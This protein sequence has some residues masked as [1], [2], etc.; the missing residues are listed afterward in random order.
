[1]MVFSKLG[2]AVFVLNQDDLT[3]LI[4]H[5]RAQHS[6]DE[7][8]VWDRYMNSKLLAKHVRREIPAPPILETRVRQVITSFYNSTETNALAYDND[9][10]GTILPKK[11][12][13]FY[14]QINGV[15]QE[16]MEIDTTSDGPYLDWQN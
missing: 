7:K 11:A 4:A 14:T 12:I 6:C 8:E 1:M 16:P 10:T 3:I 2:S 9:N 5:L 13:R 15:R